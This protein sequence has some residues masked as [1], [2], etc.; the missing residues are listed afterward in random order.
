MTSSLTSPQLAARTLHQVV[1]PSRFFGKI[2]VVGCDCL[3][4]PVDP[5]TQE[6]TACGCYDPGA[7]DYVEPGCVEVIHISEHVRRYNERIEQQ[8]RERLLKLKADAE[9]NYRSNPRADRS[10]HLVDGTVEPV[11]QIPNQEIT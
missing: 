11:V 4:F 1:R 6:A 2:K 3:S 7:F 5:V 10:A 9:R 8:K